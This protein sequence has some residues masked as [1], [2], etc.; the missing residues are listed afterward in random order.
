MSGPPPSEPTQTIDPTPA[1]EPATVR[2]SREP[3]PTPTEPVEPPILTRGDNGTKVRELQVRLI[4]EDDYA[5]GIDGVYGPRTEEAVSEFQERHGLDPTGA[6]DQDTWDEL[7]ALTGTVKESDMFPPPP[8]EPAAALDERCLVGRVI[9]ADKTNRTLSW[10]ID[11]A[12]QFSMDARFG[13]GALP[14]TNGVHEIYWK[15]RDHVSSLYDAEMPFSL[16]FH[17][18]EAVHYSYEF[19]SLGYGGPGGSH[20]CIN[21]R[22]WELTERLFREAEVGDKV[23]VFGEY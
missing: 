7:V 4:R 19:K 20:G 1:T 13:R 5:A 22:N 14:T 11:G 8:A 18:G 2:P 10:V 15:H 12:V 23:V 16:F 21:T 17:G 3:T 6:V 9:C